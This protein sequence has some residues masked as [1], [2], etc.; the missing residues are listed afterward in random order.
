MCN[1]C[2]ELHPDYDKLTM[3]HA[4]HHAASLIES[5]KFIGFEKPLKPDQIACLNAVL[6]RKDVLA[7]LPTGFG[8]SLIYQM[9]PF[10][11]THA[12]GEKLEE[13]KGFVLVITPLNGIMVDQCSNLTKRGLPACALDY[14]C[15]K[16]EFFM[17]SG[18]ESDS[19]SDSDT[20]VHQISTTVD[21]KDIKSGKY[22]VI[23]AHP[24]ALISAR[25]AEDL[26]C[27][28]GFKEN[29]LCFAIDEAHMILEW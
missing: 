12:R 25:Q 3:A 18:S 28:K 6:D 11:L 21:I 4:E 29:L 26:L 2:D 27:D 23:Y 10:A 22:R 20:H 7:V 16:G 9:A 24:E 17:D 19:D 5:Q 13:M 1:L 14:T 15:T 8:K